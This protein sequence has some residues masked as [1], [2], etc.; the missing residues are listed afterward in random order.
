MISFCILIENKLIESKNVAKR[1]PGLAEKFQERCASRDQAKFCTP[2]QPHEW[3]T[4]ATCTL[5]SYATWRG[6]GGSR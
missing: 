2:D 5:P 3:L 6:G 4:L 1:G